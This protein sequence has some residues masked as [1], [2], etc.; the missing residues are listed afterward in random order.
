[1]E[2]LVPTVRIHAGEIRLGDILVER[3][4]EGMQPWR[5]RNRVNQFVFDRDSDLAE[6]TLQFPSTL[7]KPGC[8]ID[9]RRC[10][11]YGQGGSMT[12]AFTG[13]EEVI[14]IR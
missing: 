8:E 2:M 9:P 13:A 14:V 1:M 11:H 10:L 5:G 6:V 12:S 3:A 4:R 7:C